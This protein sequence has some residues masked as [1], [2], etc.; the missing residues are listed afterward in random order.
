M[1][2][3]TTTTAAVTVML[4]CTIANFVKTVFKT[5]SLLY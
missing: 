2:I 3:M 4:M 5:G 1:M